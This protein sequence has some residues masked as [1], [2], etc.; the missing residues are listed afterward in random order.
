MSLPAVVEAPVKI[1]DAIKRASQ[2]T[3]TDFSYLLKTA[4]RE[5]S[6]NS[7]AKAK[8]SSASGLFQFIENTW[9][10]TVKEEGHQFG[11]GDYAANIS[12]TK[13]GRYYVPNASQRQEILALRNDPEISSIMAGAFTRQN[14]DYVSSRL[15]RDPTQGELYMAHF[16]G[17]KGAA[18]F[19]EL[20]GER[21]N[22]PAD[23][24]FPKAARANRPIFYANGQARSLSQVYAELVGQHAKTEAAA[25]KARAPQLTPDLPEPNPGRAIAPTETTP[26]PRE[27]KVAALAPKKLQVS[28]GTVTDI[29]LGGIGGWH[30]IVRPELESVGPAVAAPKVAAAAAA[31]AAAK[32]KPDA[33]ELPTR[34]PRR[35]GVERPVPK[36]VSD[37]NS[38]QPATPKRSSEGPLKIAS[39][40][41]EYFQ[42]DYWREVSMGGS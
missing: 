42:A 23:A 10:Q 6:F 34:K 8:T 18:R 38:R 21:P 32:T 22:A 27:I 15:G 12:R 26:P 20:A 36:P 19:I 25:A 5:S 35:R 33:L 29:G 2:A 37:A 3:G 16:L 1:T 40:S 13:S 30:T 39:A 4:A 11:L 24:H 14:A 28:P 41:F 7:S 31:P 17:P 9:L